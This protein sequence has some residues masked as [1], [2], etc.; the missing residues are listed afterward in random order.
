MWAP[1]G[2]ATAVSVGVGSAGV[3]VG[4]GVGVSGGGVALGVAVAGG[5]VA[6][7]R[8]VGR[9]VGRPGDGVCGTMVGASGG[10]IGAAVGRTAT[11]VLMGIV[12]VIGE[13][14]GFAAGR[15]V[16]PSTACVGATLAGDA[17]AT[18]SGVVRGCS[19]T[20]TAATAAVVASA[21]PVATTARRQVSV[22]ARTAGP[23]GG[24]PARDRSTTVSRSNA[25]VSA[26]Q[27]MHSEA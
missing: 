3:A 21:P 2:V 25:A 24:G 10:V 15:P 5:G 14:L 26:R 12:L 16:L 22:G 9:G 8:I 7:G 13:A 20:A 4:S 6:V 1:Q 11:G 19:A 17:A 27:T 18:G 23:I